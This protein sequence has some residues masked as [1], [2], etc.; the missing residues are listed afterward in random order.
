MATVTITV[1]PVNDA[2]VASDDNSYTVSEDEVL[3]VPLAGVLSNDTDIDNSSLS[4]VLVSGTSH[5]TL[6]LQSDGSFTYTP[7][8]N[9]HGTDSFSYQASDGSASSGVATVT[10][11]VESVNDVPLAA[12]HSYSLIRNSTLNVS[13]A[14]VL[15]GASDADGDPLTAVLVATPSHGVLN[16]NSD[17]SF[18]YTPAEDYEGPDSF[19]Y[20]AS[21]GALSSTISLVSFTVTHGTPLPADDGYSTSED[22]SLVVDA[23]AGV[24]ANDTDAEGDALTVVVEEEPGHGSLTL[25]A[26]GSFSYTPEAN[27][28]GSDSFRYRASDPGGASSTAVVTI[29][30]NSLNDAPLAADDNYST[31]EDETLNVAASGVLAGDTDVDGDSLTAA[32]VTGP[33]HGNLTFN[34]DGSFVYTP[35]ADFSG[36]DSFTYSATDPSGSSSLAVVHIAVS[37]VNDAPLVLDD[38]YSLDEDGSLSVTAAGLL[39]NDTDVEGNPL[40]ATLVSGPAHGTLSM[41]SNGSF[42]YT[43]DPDYH[44][45]DSFTYQAGDGALASAAA[46]ATINV[47]PINDA[48]VAVGESYGVNWNEALSVGCQASCPATATSTAIR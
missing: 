13:A 42:T 1:N 25:N 12:D 14:G 26:D 39:I 10:I 8:A 44:G 20:Q 33:Q 34:S 29:T 47:N 22:V 19:G 23:A 46:T 21:D 11:T 5:G 40:T 32:L 4:A 48:P 7:E 9:F 38:S 37:Q 30:V 41:S 45:P 18:S 31:S 16:L 17:G 43:P 36:A 28:H 6:S 3:S 24:L 27:F 35:N 15:L 2:P